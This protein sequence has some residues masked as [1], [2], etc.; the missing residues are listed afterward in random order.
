MKGRYVDVTV[1]EVPR[2]ID[3]ATYSEAEVAAWS[4]T[5]GWSESGQLQRR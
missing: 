1:T 5:E 3:L 4:E 2:V